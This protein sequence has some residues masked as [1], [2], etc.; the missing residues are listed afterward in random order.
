M[1]TFSVE[2]K[3]KLAERHLWV[4]AYPLR[5]L[6]C[7]CMYLRVCGKKRFAS[8]GT[9]WESTTS[10]HTTTSQSDPTLKMSRSAHVSTTPVPTPSHC[11]R[12]GKHPFFLDE[13]TTYTGSQFGG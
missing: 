9:I 10:P 5:A 13:T 4:H 8:S 12:T 3:Q 7:F 2:R 1:K 6:S 11:P